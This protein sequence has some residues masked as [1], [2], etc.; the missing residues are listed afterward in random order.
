MKRTGGLPFDTEQI[1]SARSDIFV[2]VTTTQYPF[3]VMHIHN[4]GD[5]AI[6]MVVRN[7]FEIRPLL[8]AT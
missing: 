1:F 7:S 6:F 8:F 3:I 2:A 5:S 4:G